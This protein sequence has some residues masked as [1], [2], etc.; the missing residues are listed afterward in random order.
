MFQG[1]IFSSTSDKSNIDFIHAALAADI[2]FES[3]PSLSQEVVDAL[4]W[5]AARSPQQIAEERESILRNLETRA[6]EL[7]NTGAHEAWLND[8]DPYVKVI[9]ESVNGPLLAALA[10]ETNYHDPDCVDI[11]RVGA[12]LTGPLQVSGNGKQIDPTSRFDRSIACKRS[13]A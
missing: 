1:A 9:S 3:S 10:R 13:A 11:F 4:D 2:N 8:A 6:E 7:V 12:P 5:M